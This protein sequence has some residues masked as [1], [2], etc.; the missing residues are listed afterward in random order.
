M[1]EHQWRLTHESVV[2]KK[3]YMCDRCNAIVSGYGSLEEIIT[4]A[5]FGL[6]VRYG[7]Q[8]AFPR[9]YS[10][11]DFMLATLVQES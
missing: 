11:C 10:D 7:K 8:K 9:R 3:Y 5:R 1:I 6:I 4:W 2:N